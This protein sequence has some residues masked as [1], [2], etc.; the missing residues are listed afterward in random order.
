MYDV[1]NEQ[2]LPAFV[3]LMA[4]RMMTIPTTVENH[5]LVDDVT[6]WIHFSSFQFVKSIL[7]SIEKCSLKPGL[8]LNKSSGCL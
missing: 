3:V 6:D 1:I 5:I 7:R 2:P 8:I 4:D